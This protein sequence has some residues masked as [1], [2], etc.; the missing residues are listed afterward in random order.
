MLDQQQ[1]HQ[2]R[3]PSSRRAWVEISSSGKRSNTASASP[4]SRR[5]WVEICL[6]WTDN[7]R[8]WESPSS[9]RAWVEIGG[10]DSTVLADLASPSSRRAWVE[11]QALCPWRMLWGV[12]LLTE[13]VGRN[14]RCSTDTVYHGLSPSSRRAW[15]EM[16]WGYH[17]PAGFESPSSRRA[18]VEIATRTVPRERATGRPPHGGR[19]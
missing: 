4:S 5:A 18:W 9:R 3:S 8:R 12:A 1:R 13:G 17:Y 16:I 10:K 14:C 19:G 2:Q 15:V 6:S 7:Q 11:I